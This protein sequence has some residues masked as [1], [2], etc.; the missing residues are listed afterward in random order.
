MNVREYSKISMIKGTLMAVE[1][2][3]DA[4]YNELVD[5]ETSSGKKR[6][7]VVDS[8][9]GVSIVQVFEGTT[10]VSPTG[11]KV[12][13]LGRGLEV[14]ISEEMLGRIFNPLG[15]PLD[16]GPEIIKG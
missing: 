4:S 6:G 1:G 13:M 3:S 14:K 10:G 16:N 9:M 5:I 12:R 8:Q 11:T 15:D 7:I 2:V